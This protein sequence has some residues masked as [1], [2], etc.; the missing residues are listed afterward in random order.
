MKIAILGPVNTEKYFGGVAVFTEELADAFKRLGHDV[1]IYTDYAG[2]RQQ[3]Y[4]GVRLIAVD[5]K[6]KRKKM[7]MIVKL[8][9]FLVEAKPEVIISSLE[10]SF[11]VPREIKAIK[12]HF[13]HGFVSIAQYG[14]AQFIA[15][16]VLN[17]YIRKHFDYVV[18]N[19]NFT[20]MIN[21]EIFGLHVDAVINPG[22][23][24]EF[25]QKLKNRT[26]KP[27]DERSTDV[28]FVGRLVRAKRVDTL[29]KSLAYLSSSYKRKLTCKIIGAGPE[30]NKLRDLARKLAVSV[31]F[32]GKMNQ[33]NIIDEYLDSKVFVSL[34]PH[35]PFGIVFLE[36][37]LSGCK[38]VCPQTG[39]QL[40]FLR[41]YPE[42]VEIVDAY[43]PHK[44]AEG[45]IR[46]LE[47][48]YDSNSTSVNPENFSYERT[49]REILD[50]IRSR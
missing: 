31:T 29:I 49:A 20:R 21:E 18:A 37:L 11:A 45:I 33:A 4:Y 9:N 32:C 3:T 24:K 5:N 1:A 34:N 50:L 2:S 22:V 28:L 16:H 19:S 8:R 10:Y 38:I 15:H 23:P 13:L 12:I 47:S 42:T 7:F 41:L 27:K 14:Y 43:S 25:I 48:P 40:D 39:G 46:C 6:P 36:A 17:K 30:E 44:V 26:L 35:E